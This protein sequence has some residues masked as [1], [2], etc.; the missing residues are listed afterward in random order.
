VPDN[1]H[2]PAF[3][4]YSHNIVE[5]ATQEVLQQP[6]H[7]NDEN[8]STVTEMVHTVDGR[9][10]ESLTALE[11]ARAETEAD[12]I[13]MEICEQEKE[14]RSNNATEENNVENQNE[15]LNEKDEDVEG[16]TF[17]NNCEDV[18]S[19]VRD[20]EEKDHEDV[21]ETLRSDMREETD[22]EIFQEAEP[23]AVNEYK[24]ERKIGE[25][26]TVTEQPIVIPVTH[27][28]SE[29]LPKKVESN[30]EAS[31][32]SNHTTTSIVA[33]INSS[34]REISRVESGELFSLE[35]SATEEEEET[36][37][38]PMKTRKKSIPKQ[39]KYHNQKDHHKGHIQQHPNNASKIEAVSSRQTD[40]QPQ[41]NDRHPSPVQ[42]TETTPFSES[43]SIVDPR[44]ADIS[45]RMSSI[46]HSPTSLRE[47]HD[48]SVHQA[49]QDAVRS[50]D[51]IAMQKLL[52]ETADAQRGLEQE[53]SQLQ[54]SKKEQ[55]K[56]ISELSGY[57]RT[58]D[59]IYNLKL[60]EREIL[61]RELTQQTHD[62]R[63]QVVRDKK[64]FD[65]MKELADCN[66]PKIGIQKIKARKLASAGR[67]EEFPYFKLDLNSNNDVGSRPASSSGLQA[68]NAGLPDGSSSLFRS[69]PISSPALNLNDTVHSAC[70]SLSPSRRSQFSSTGINT[71]KIEQSWQEE[72]VAEKQLGIN[73]VE[74][75]TNTR[76]EVEEVRK[77]IALL[78]SHQEIS[79]KR[80]RAKPAGTI[81]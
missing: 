49:D 60:K 34:L 75:S 24:D 53:V 55:D 36:E 17:I 23:T 69:R 3:D 44:G 74:D 65:E 78:M 37:V 39:S 26:E 72:P 13:N 21:V 18:T 6:D 80:L 19:E 9:D 1:P 2:V 43:Y 32:T 40:V 42:V 71:K 52:S 62:L 56:Y 10:E 66:L 57:I 22:D 48:F 63:A 79:L 12:V 7:G 58:Q 16:V 11:T 67:K 30:D 38:A 4:E 59:H 73:G 77:K 61:L 76:H 47:S 45:A 35:M 68:F 50:E 33:D 70:G 28:T 54:K 41:K 15:E 20:L 27:S 14:E 64:V 81:N 25:V 46:L 51:F 5:A 31:V 8:I 29:L